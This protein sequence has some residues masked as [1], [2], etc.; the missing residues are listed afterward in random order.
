[1]VSP[2]YKS[3]GRTI[4][5]FGK[6]PGLDLFLNL[7]KRVVLDFNLSTVSGFLIPMG[8]YP[9]ILYNSFLA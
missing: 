1:M 5:V 2:Q 3:S 7:I 6:N 8:E 9:Q 4:Q